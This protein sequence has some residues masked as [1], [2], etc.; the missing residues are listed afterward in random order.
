MGVLLVVMATGSCVLLTPLQGARSSKDQ[1]GPAL[2]P[3]YY[4][5]MEL[6]GGVKVEGQ[7]GPKALTDATSVDERHVHSIDEGRLPGGGVPCKG[8]C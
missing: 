4:L 8:F 6:G 7:L 1:P 3:Q 2:W 5:R